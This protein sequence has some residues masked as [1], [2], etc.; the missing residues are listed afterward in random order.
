MESFLIAYINVWARRVQ[1]SEESPDMSEDDKKMVRFACC[2]VHQ[3]INSILRVD[4]KPESV[5][6]KLVL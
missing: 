5:S 4:D 1:I 2:A 3:D 6:K